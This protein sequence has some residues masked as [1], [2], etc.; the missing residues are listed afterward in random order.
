MPRQITPSTS[1]TTLRREAKR[2]LRALRSGDAGARTRLEAAYPSAPAMP[3]L[4]DVQHALARE[5]GFESWVALRE[6]LG[7]DEGRAEGPAWRTLGA[8]GYERLADDL[9]Q[10]FG[11]R[12]AAALA[13]LNAHYQRA[14]TFDDLWAEVWRRVYAFR[15]RAFTARNQHLQ[16]D[17]AR[18]LIAQDAGFS[19]WTALVA[20]AST[21]AP[22]VPPYE[23]DLAASRISPRRHLAPSEWETLI[24]VMKERRISRLDA[25][26][27]MTDAMLARVADLDHVTAIGLG[28]SRELSDDGLHHLARMPQLQE[29]D[30]SEYPGGKLTDRGLEVLRHLP[31][32]RV[33]EMTWQRGITDAGVVNLRFCD[34]LERVNLMGSPTGDGAID[35]L[36]GK[37]MLRQ[38]SSG[39][40]VTD[41]G[42]RL[43]QNFPKFKTWHGGDDWS[44]PQAVAAGAAH[45]LID[46]P[47]TNEGLAGLTGLDGVGALDLF[48]HVTGITAEGFVHLAGLPN[49]VTLGADGAL[50]DNVSLAHIGA[51]PRLRALRAQEAVATDE[52]FEALSRSQTLER[53]WGRVCPN[54]GSRG[55][56][57][58]STMP[59]LRALGI[60]CANVDDAALARLP[61][62]PSL[63][64]LTPIG[65]TDPGFRHV[66]GCA[67]L[68]RLT[69]MYCRD[70]TDVATEH[71]AGLQ[72]K[73]Y[74]A[75]LTKITDRSLE[76]LARMTSLEQIDLYECSGV[77][78]VG[79]AHLAGLPRLREVHLDSLPG[80]TIDGTRTLPARVKV[81]YST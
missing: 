50:S 43:L 22:P 24:G 47:F 9:V 32:L 15:Q 57:A 18:T 38:F 64:E 63:R 21:G 31:N 7:G 39:R 23:L 78:D 59:S 62:F 2:W 35:A 4:R 45:L 75:G 1:L 70:T 71:I 48:W 79:I 44:D 81:H 69:C 61:E 41:A 54:F 37:P 13:R 6:A 20:A 60:G 77:T 28:G 52:G 58:L 36:Q 55:F 17:E 53:L 49:L 16:L 5:Y 12:D 66:G 3:V 68:E 10:A 33:F 67:R 76:I 30:L 27:L 80:V 42:L 19:S 56:V 72:L 73:Y 34:R 65:V 29:L 51:I 26:G 11:A 74:Y 46:G 40:A 25:N 8:D 14:F